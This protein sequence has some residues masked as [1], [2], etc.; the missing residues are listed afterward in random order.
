MSGLIVTRVLL[1][2]SPTAQRSRRA[3]TMLVPA[4]RWSSELP[5]R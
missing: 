4:L 3:G 1:Q 2:R 5:R